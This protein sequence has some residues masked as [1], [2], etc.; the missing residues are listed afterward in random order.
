ML[1]ALR[2]DGER[3]AEPFAPSLLRVKAGRC[4]AAVKMTVCAPTLRVPFCV[5]VVLAERRGTEEF[6]LA[7]IRS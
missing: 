4:F 7:L 5:Q 3:S 1:V 2:A 6:R